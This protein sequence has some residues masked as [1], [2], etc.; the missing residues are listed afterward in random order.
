MISQ[1]GSDIHRRV[2]C[3]TDIEKPWLATSDMWMPPLYGVAT[4]K[5]IGHSPPDY[6]NASI[7]G[8]KDLSAGTE[9]V[10]MD[11]YKGL[12]PET[13]SRTTLPPLR[14]ISCGLKIAL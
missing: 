3:G 12:D 6:S 13:Q 2:A 14:M 11:R 4:W 8:R 9:S 5:P 1:R 7:A 10:Y